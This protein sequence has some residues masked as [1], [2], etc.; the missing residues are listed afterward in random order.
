MTQSNSNTAGILKSFEEGSALSALNIIFSTF[1]VYN[2]I[3]SSLG[4]KN[5][6]TSIQALNHTA[7]KLQIQVDEMITNSSP[8]TDSCG[9]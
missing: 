5:P 3:H 2:L 1:D 9:T 6:D 8:E 7:Y 4:N